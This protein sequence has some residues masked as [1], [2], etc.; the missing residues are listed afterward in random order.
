MKEG[1][2]QGELR[3][4]I[5]SPEYR[6]RGIST[7][8][9]RTLVAHARK[10]GV[11]SIFLLTSQFNI[12]ARQLYKKLGWVEQGRTW[13]QVGIL[14]GWILSFKLD[15]TGAEDATVSG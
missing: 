9:V 12:A 10:N 3:R 8:L 2:L 4:M 13:K 15:L 5:V 14:G 6:R 1:T 11:P 7:S